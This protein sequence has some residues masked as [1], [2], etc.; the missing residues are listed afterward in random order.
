MRSSKKKAS[1]LYGFGPGEREFSEELAKSEVEVRQG[2]GERPSFAKSIINILNG[3]KDSINR[4][5]FEVDPAQANNYGG[6]YQAKLRL[7]PDSVLKRIAIQDSLVAAIVRARQNHMSSFGRA[8]PERFGL[9][10]IVKPNTGVLDIMD[11]KEKEEFGKRIDKA[12]RLISSC[13]HTEGVPTDHQKTFA[14]YLSLSAR[15]AVVCGRIATEIVWVQDS[16]GGERRFSHFVATDAGTIYRA[17]KDKNSQDAVRK[18]A[19][20]LMCTLIGGDKKPTE[21]KWN[22][23]EYSWVQ[24]IDGTPKMVFTKDEMRVYNFY[25]VP[26]VELAGYPVTPIDTVITAVTTHINITTHNKLYFQSGRASRGMLVITSDDVDK[27][28]LSQIKQNFNASI[29]SVS[30]SWR[31]PVFG[32]PSD[33]TLQWQPLDTGGGRDMEFQY[34]ADMNAREILTAFMMSPDELPGYSYLSRGTASQALSECIVGESVITTG[35]GTVQ[36]ADFVGDAKEREGTFWSGEKWVKGRAFKSGEKQLVETEL[37]CGLKLKSSPDH[38]FRV[39]DS[40]GDLAWKHQSELKVGD[41]VLV[42]RTPVVGDENLVPSFNGKKMTPEIAEILGW[43]IGD[44]CISPPLLH[45]GAAISIFYHHEKEE[46]IWKDQYQKLKEFGVNVGQY[47]RKVS[48][49]EKE[50]I[51]ARYDIANVADRRIRNIS[52]DTDF[53]SW[54]MSLGFTPS[55]KELGGKSIPPLFGVLPVEYRRAF[56]RGLFSADGGVIDKTGGVCLTIQNDKL[57]EQVRQLLIGV[58]IRTLHWNGVN[59][60]SLGDKTKKTFSHKLVVKDRNVFWSDIGFIQAH[61]QAGKK[62]QKW[63]IDPVPLGVL[64][65]YLGK[66]LDT[67]G[68]RALSKGKRDSVKSILVGKSNCSYQLFEKT[69]AVCGVDKPEWVE[70]YYVES[71]FS[72]RDLEQKVGMYDVEMYDDVHAFIVNGVLTHNSNNEWK[73]QAARDVGIRPLLAQFEDFINA[74]LFPLIDPV[75]ATKARICLVGLEADTQE[76]ESTRLQTA[77][78]VYMTFD[79]ILQKVEKKPVGKEWGGEFPMN[80]AYQ[81][82]VDKYLYVGDVLEHFFGRKGASKDPSLH[83]IHDPMWFQYQQMLL[84]QQQMAAQQQAQA[85]QPQGQPPPQDGGGGGQDGQDGGGEPSRANPQDDQTETQRTAAA[86]PQAPELGSAVSQ[87][88]DLMQKSEDNLPSDKRQVLARHKKSLEF[89][90]TGFERDVKTGVKEILDLA[91]KVGPRSK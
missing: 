29:N 76:K 57:R 24:V 12:I 26:D 81:A 52:Y 21:E 3:E 77:S 55:T 17:T 75:L 73:L 66:V 61:K 72:V 16:V 89:F 13:G 37:N 50:K 39:I 27:N 68:Y 69:L 10:F 64:Q 71:V 74:E 51:K 45:S 60:W 90:L 15:S 70:K 56:L 88:Y 63:S 9:G 5:A 46:N 87:A 38:R 6:I 8:R 30:N 78:Q 48:E 22:R 32:I 42:N 58:G 14:E 49:E 83:Y 67:D 23:D 31:M 18:E 34:L 36:I 54:L 53:Y 7:V 84:Q 62:E 41:K 86:Q 85:Q 79:D 59:R 4:L 82:I 35:Q 20:H 40:N 11:E 47:D 44:G 1:I 28:M 43:M 80:P 91:G 33:S 65:K 2:K 25:P 19:Y